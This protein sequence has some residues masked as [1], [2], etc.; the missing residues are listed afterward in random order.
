MASLSSKYVSPKEMAEELKKL[1][2]VIQKVLNEEPNVKG[3]K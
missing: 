1:L 2:R 3:D